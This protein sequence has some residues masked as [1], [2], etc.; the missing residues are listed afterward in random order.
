[1][2]RQLER[3]NLVWGVLLVVFGFAAFIESFST[4]TAWGWAGVLAATGLFVFGI[5]RQDRSDWGLLLP[6]YI[7]WAI[8][9]MIVLIELY[10]LRGEAIAFYVLSAIALPFVYTYWKNREAWWF[11]IP[12]YVLLAVG[13]MVGLIGLEWLSDFMIPAYVMFAIATPFFMVYARNRKNW[14]ALIPAG[15][16]GV[17]GLGFVMASPGFRFIIPLALVVAGVWI[18][19]RQ[20]L[21]WQT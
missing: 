15:I 20:F 18:L 14:W 10:I 1:M 5:Y 12:A 21:P 6:T 17:I 8:A 11:L 4:L 2:N 9:A 13:L 3:Y 19:V 16:M 7:L